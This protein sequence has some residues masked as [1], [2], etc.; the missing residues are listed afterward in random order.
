MCFLP[1]ESFLC[2]FLTQVDR[3]GGCRRWIWRGHQQ[4]DRRYRRAGHCR[5]KR[6]QSSPETDRCG[7]EWC[8]IQ[9]S[10][11]Q[12]SQ[13]GRHSCAGNQ[14][15]LHRYY[16]CYEVNGHPV[17][18]TKFSNSVTLFVGLIKTNENIILEEHLTKINYWRNTKL[19]LNESGFG[20]SVISIIF[21]N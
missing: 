20:A 17:C 10:A 9:I 13:V 21:S 5:T 16:T 18:F 15:L 4:R 1:V 11:L 14:D 3:D 19:H 12:D 6:P 2:G 8:G 7:F